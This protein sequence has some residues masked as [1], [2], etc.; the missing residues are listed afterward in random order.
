MIGRYYDE[1][2]ILVVVAYCIFQQVVAYCIFQQC[3][4]SLASRDDRF[5]CARDLWCNMY[6]RQNGIYC[7]NCVIKLTESESLT[8]LLESAALNG[9]TSAN[10]VC[11]INSN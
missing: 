9:S 1:E 8:N 5:T 10:A 4:R 11:Q 2:Y 3:S 6:K 7:L